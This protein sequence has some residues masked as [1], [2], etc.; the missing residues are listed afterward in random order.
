V[1]PLVRNFPDLRLSAWLRHQHRDL[2]EKVEGSLE[3]YNKIVERLGL[4][5]TFKGHL[6]QLLVVIRDIFHWIRL[7]RAPSNLTWNVS[8]DGA[9]ATSLGNLC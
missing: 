7:L 6:V 2:L 5:R 3:S 4:D 9:S 1:F 8:R